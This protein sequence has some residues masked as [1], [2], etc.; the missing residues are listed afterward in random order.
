[1]STNIVV[2]GSNGQLG[3]C[4]QLIAKNDKDCN[5]QFLNSSEFDITSKNQIAELFN[6]KTIQYVVN[7]AAYTNVEQAEKEPEK[8]YLVN[9]EGVRLL[10][11]ACKEHNA[12]LI[13]ISTDYVFDGSKNTAYT[14]EDVPN[15][16][17]EY[18]KSKLVGEKYIQEILEHYFIIRT[19]WLYSQ[20][21]KNFYKTILEKSKSQEKLTIVD[22]E[23]GTPTNANDLARFIL[24][25]IT[26]NFNNYGI[27]HYSNEGQATWYDFAHE[28]LRFSGKLDF[29]KL[30]KTNYYPSFAKRPSYSV[31]NKKKIITYTKHTPPNWKESLLKI[32]KIAS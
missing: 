31:L 12:I 17:N 20:F 32:Q 15:P 1:M 3:R 29:I 24:D 16:I 14:E 28:I 5:F 26:M 27:Y 23:I 22:S 11:E 18:G 6:S 19:S 7:C 9:A 30:D 4:L 2:T 21:G 25:L 8:A 10:A 13:H